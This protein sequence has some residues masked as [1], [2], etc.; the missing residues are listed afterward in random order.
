MTVAIEISD[1]GGGARAYHTIGNVN[2]FIEQLENAVNNFVSAVDVLDTL[3]F[4]L[5]SEDHWKINL[6]QRHEEVNTTLCR[7]LLMIGKIDE[8]LFV[9]KEGL[10]QTFS[11]NLLI[12]RPHHLPNLTPKKYLFS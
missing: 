11:D 5:K 12:S 6:R 7:S 8:A 2:F 9:A 10:V 4:L 1:Q 3:K